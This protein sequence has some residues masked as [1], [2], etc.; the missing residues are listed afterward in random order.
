MTLNKGTAHRG[1]TVTAATGRSRRGWA[2]SQGLAREALPHVGCPE[3][4][5]CAGP[6]AGTSPS[7][8]SSRAARTKQ[9]WAQ[10]PGFCVTAT[11]PAALLPPQCPA[12]RGHS[13]PVPPQPLAARGRT[14]R[15]KQQHRSRHR[16]KEQLAAVMPWS[17]P[18]THL[19]QASLGRE[20]TQE[21]NGPM[22]ARWW[23]SHQ[24][25]ASRR[26]HLPPRRAQRGKV[27]AFPARSPGY[28]DPCVTTRRA[29]P[30]RLC[31]KH[32]SFRRGTRRAGR[33]RVLSRAPQ[34]LPQ[35]W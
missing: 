30:W 32:P 34:L 11:S 1:G 31:P 33:E 9:I 4:P 6:P 14:Q 17:F 5:P 35:R 18:A 20:G 2:V 22:A 21:G 8:S 12:C 15:V 16:K 10:S 24:C 19:Q 28:G 13:P 26:H 27:P 7:R 3:T 25:R 29:H 23:H